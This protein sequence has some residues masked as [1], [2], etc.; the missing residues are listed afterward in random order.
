MEVE[1]LPY[2]QAA[3]YQCVP[4]M[5]GYHSQQQAEMVVDKYHEYNEGASKNDHDFLHD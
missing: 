3:A 5:G 2:G 4:G 1:A